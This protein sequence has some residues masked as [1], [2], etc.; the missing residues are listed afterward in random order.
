MVA[1]AS[2]TTRCTA[3]SGGYGFSFEETLYVVSPGR[4]AAGLP[5]A[6]AGS[7]ARAGRNRT[8]GR[9]ASSASW[10]MGVTVR[11]GTDISG[12]AGSTRQSVED[13]RT[14]VYACPQIRP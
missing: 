11:P 7:A 9:A 12:D 8:D 2:S 5:G 1:A 10:L 14:D 6:Y 3:G 4:A 13:C